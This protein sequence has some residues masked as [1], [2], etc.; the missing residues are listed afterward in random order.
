LAYNENAAGT[1]AKKTTIDHP[2]IVNLW[3]EDES[4][5]GC[6]AV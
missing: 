6:S 5:L 2:I 1:T 3:N 4:L